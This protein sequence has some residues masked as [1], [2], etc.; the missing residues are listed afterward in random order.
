MPNSV[1]TETGTAITI[2]PTTTTITDTSAQQNSAD[3]LTNS[4]KIALMQQYSAELAIKTQLDTAASSVSIS[5]TN[6]DNAVAAINTTLVNA[7]A[8]STWATTWPDGTTSGPWSGIQTSLATDWSNVA[9]TRTALQNAVSSAQAEQAQQAAI[10]AAA[11]DA[12]T[13]ANNAITTAESYSDAATALATPDVVSALPTLPSSSYPTGKMVWNTT[14]GQLYR[15]TGSAWTVLAINGTNITLGSV[16]M[17]QLAAGSVGTT[18]LA[19]Q[20]ATI[21][22]LTIVDFDN[23]W[24]NGNSERNPPT[25]ADTTGVEFGSR[26]NAGSGAYAGNWVRQIVAG[27]SEVNLSLEIPCNAGDTFMAQCQTKVINGSAAAGICAYCV[28]GSGNWLWPPSTA[29]PNAAGA[30]GTTNTVWTLCG[31][32]MTVPATA[33][34]IVIYLFSLAGVTAQFDQIYVRK[35]AD[36]SLLVDGSVVSRT[37]ATDSVDSTKMAT[38]GLTVG[39]SASMPISLMAVDAS[40]NPIASIGQLGTQGAPVNSAWGTPYGIWAKNLALGG[41]EAAPALWIDNSGNMVGNNGS[42]IDLLGNVALKNI[43]SVSGVT[44]SPTVSTS[45]LT[46]LPELGTSNAQMTVTTKGNPVLVA[47]NLAFAAA[48]GT[49]TSG[50]VIGIGTSFTSR[51]ISPAPYIAITISGDGSG[52]SASVAWTP[53][54]GYLWPKLSIQGGTGYTAATAT[55]TISNSTGSNTSS[56]PNGTTTYT[57]V[58][59]TG[60]AA[61][62]ALIEAQVLMDSG[63]VMGPFNA[64]SDANGIATINGTQ[65]L[66]A[67]AGSHSFEVQALNKSSSLTVTSTARTFCLVELG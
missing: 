6:Y 9:T 17:G 4:D 38:S 34:S 53:L 2:T 39:G 66:G 23:L 59:G 12:T 50:P 63:V 46:D 54:N 20:S 47:I 29:L 51:A 55:V 27:A 5:S 18:Q 14:D 31:W 61:A 13:K 25:G 35:C 32:T 62:G 33:V 49:T 65:L 7:G 42:A 44:Q 15:S 67:V 45:A 36:A 57:C 43:V 28:D 1:W 60:Q 56:Y 16:T 48:T 64:T 41:S 40:A 3:Y 37:I 52:A 30:S 19:A 58:I 10:Q 8:P 26:Y 11:T 21:D 22:K 24:T